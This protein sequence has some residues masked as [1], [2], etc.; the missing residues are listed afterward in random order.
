MFWDR[1]WWNPWGMGTKG[2]MF[3]ESITI[4]LGKKNQTLA[5]ENHLDTAKMAGIR[6][7]TATAP[8]TVNVTIAH[9]Y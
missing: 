1:Q 2:G 8:N 3:L 7:E 4:A 5:R 6:S 9:I